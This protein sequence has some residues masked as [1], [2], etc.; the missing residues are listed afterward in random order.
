MKNAILYYP[1]KLQRRKNEYIPTTAG[2]TTARSKPVMPPCYIDLILRLL[3]LLPL[4]N[5]LRLTPGGVLGFIFKEPVLEF[6][7]LP[8]NECP[9]QWRIYTVKFWTR[10]QPSVQIP[11]L[12]PATKLGQAYVF[13]GVC[14]SVNRG[15]GGVCLSACWDTPPRAD[16]PPEQTLPWSRHPPEQTP[17]GADTPPE[18]T[19][20]KPD[21]PQTKYTPQ[22]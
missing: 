1:Q 19:S 15:G 2:K 9:Q 7:K 22:D 14:H 8:K 17:P 10:V 13:T 11:S 5:V 18:Q 3:H 21:T 16:M 4:I 20:P 6:K 12:P